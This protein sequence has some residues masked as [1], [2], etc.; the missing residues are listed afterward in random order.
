MGSKPWEEMPTRKE[1]YI[2][3]HENGGKNQGTKF[4]ALRNTNLKECYIV[5]YADDFSI[6][7]NNLKDA[8]R[9]FEARK[10]WLKDRLGLEISPEKSKIVNLKK[11]YSEFLGFKLKVTPKRK[12][13]NGTAKY[14]IKA[15]IQDKK[16][17]K[18]KAEVREH[19]KDIQNSSTRNQMA[20]QVS[21]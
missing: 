16:I 14:T 12:T 10:Q 15:H 13:A 17:K 7:V 6:S 2:Q 4:R 21:L 20:E 9:L 3:Y 1:Y 18:I 8:K 5:R 11:H 19:I